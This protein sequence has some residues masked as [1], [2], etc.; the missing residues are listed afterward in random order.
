MSRNHVIVP[1]DVP[2]S[3]P[4][5]LDAF[6]APGMGDVILR[7]RPSEQPRRSSR[8]DPNHL[9]PNWCGPQPQRAMGKTGKARCC[10]FALRLPKSRRLPESLLVPLALCLDDWIKM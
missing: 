9:D 7:L 6:R 2:P 5:R 8:Y 1:V 10:L 3:P 4:A